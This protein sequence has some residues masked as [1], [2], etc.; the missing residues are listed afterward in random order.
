MVG[1]GMCV[2]GEGLLF[3]EIVFGWCY[4]W[5]ELMLLDVVF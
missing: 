4:G 1:K 5:L 2:V 3:V